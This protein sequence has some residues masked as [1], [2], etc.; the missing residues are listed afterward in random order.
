MSLPL[1]ILII[2][3]LIGIIIFL[4]LKYPKKFK[5]N[6]FKYYSDWHIIPINKNKE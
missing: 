3:I 1:F 4:R 6:I 5:F 2:S